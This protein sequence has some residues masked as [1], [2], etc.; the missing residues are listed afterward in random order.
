MID[1]EREENIYSFGFI[2]NFY[3]PNTIT[4]GA[5]LLPLL[6]AEYGKSIQ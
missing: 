4:H 3:P 2:L 6:D 5:S 1:E